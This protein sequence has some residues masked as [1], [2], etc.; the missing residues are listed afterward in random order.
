MDGIIINDEIYKLV[1]DGEDFDCK[2]CALEKYCRNSKSN[3]FL[4]I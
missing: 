4:L 3:L 1:E 2:D